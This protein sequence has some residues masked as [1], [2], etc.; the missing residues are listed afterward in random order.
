M[1]HLIRRTSIGRKVSSTDAEA[2]AAEHATRLHD[3]FADNTEAVLHISVEDALLIA[4]AIHDGRQA[5]FL[6]TGKLAEITAS[7]HGVRRCDISDDSRIWMYLIAQNP[8]ARSGAGGSRA[9]T[10]S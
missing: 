3:Q 4:D 7:K 9:H 5:I 8:Q 2:A 10:S 6:S 1:M